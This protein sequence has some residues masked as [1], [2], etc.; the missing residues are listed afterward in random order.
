MDIGV[1]SGDWVHPN[2]THDH[3]ERWG[4]SG[5]ARVGQYLGKIQGHR[6]IVGTLIYDPRHGAF[7]IK[8]AYESVHDVDVVWMQRLM[9]NGIA[10][11]MRTAQK[12]GQIIIN[13]VDDWYWG[14]HP[15]NNAFKATHPKFSPDLNISH[16][17]S[18]LKHSNVLMSSTEYLRDRLRDKFQR[19]LM[20]I[21]NYI[22]VDKFAVRQHT[23]TDVPVVG[24]AGST[25]H[26]SRDLET[27]RGVVDAMYR[28][29]QIK[30]HHTGHHP[31]GKAFH[32]YFNLSPEDV[33]TLPLSDH[34]T[35]PKSLVFDVGIVPLNDT[36]FNHAK[37]DI[38]GLEYSASGI[39]FV[40]Q[41]LSAYRWLKKEFGIGRTADRPHDWIRHLKSLRWAEIRKEEGAMNRELVKARDISVGTAHLQQLFDS[42]KG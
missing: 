8:T 19:D 22:D 35:Y 27:V 34:E 23:D 24:W 31:G 33:T 12:Q 10:D 6:F 14:L 17:A 7:Q 26:R 1:A 29:G 37:S 21:P 15:T 16:Y 25:A 18:I 13:D 20:L 9:H 30:L 5:W 42:L 32:E 38:K 28:Q 41:S 2:H 36:P 11:N 39:P 3:K 40:A 4:G